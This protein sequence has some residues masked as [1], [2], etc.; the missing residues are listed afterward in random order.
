MVDAAKVVT[1]LERIEYVED[2][3]LG[4]DSYCV[5]EMHPDGG[6]CSVPDYA[7]IKLFRHIV[8]GEGPDTI[9]RENDEAIQAL[10]EGYDTVC[11]TGYSLRGSGSCCPLHG[12]QRQTP[13]CCCWMRSP[14]VWMPRRR[15]V[16]G[17]PCVRPP[18]GAP[19]SPFPTASMR[20][21]AAGLWRSGPRDSKYWERSPGGRKT[22]GAAKCWGKKRLT[23]SMGSVMMNRGRRDLFQPSTEV[24]VHG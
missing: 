15:P 5:V 4:K 16:Y 8:Q 21:L 12:P 18:V 13:L 9:G 6:A 7:V 20:V 2:P 3:H 17:R 24:N 22:S 11:T 23:A 14:P 10:P 1:E 19:S